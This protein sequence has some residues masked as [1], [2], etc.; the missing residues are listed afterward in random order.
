MALPSAWCDHLFAKLSLRWGAAFLRQWPDTDI[1]AVK[2]DW[3]DV[4][5][6]CTGHSLSYALRYLPA[7][8]CNALQF[9]DLCRRAPAQALPALTDD[10]VRAD[11]DRVRALVAGVE[12]RA[13]QLSPAQRCAEAILA[14]ARGRGRMSPAQRAQIEAM[15]QRLTPLQRT[16]AAAFVPSLADMEA[17]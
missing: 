12:R 11:P 15:R 6:G 2:D 4:L 8:P 3:A 16:Q 5:D 10:G 13:S 1:E 7:A 9:R 14:S 17:P